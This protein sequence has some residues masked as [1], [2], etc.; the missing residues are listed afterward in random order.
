M[1]RAINEAKVEESRPDGEGY[2]R[3]AVTWRDNA[4]EERVSIFVGIAAHEAHDVL[5]V[6]RAIHHAAEELVVR[7]L[8]IG[9]IR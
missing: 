7:A 2:R 9:R 8:V 1:S 5:A 3:I 6:A 4:G